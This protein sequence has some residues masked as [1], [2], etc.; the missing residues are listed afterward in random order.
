MEAIGGTG[1]SLTGLLT[2]LCGI[3]YKPEEAAVVAAKVN[4]WTGHYAAPNPATQ[5]AELID[6]IPQALANLLDGCRKT[7]ACGRSQSSRID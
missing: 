4:R 6:K 5:I 1:D 7:N 3:D 2:V